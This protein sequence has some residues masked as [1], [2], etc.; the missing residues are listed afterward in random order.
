M[1]YAEW[2][3]SCIFFKN[4]SEFPFPD[5]AEGAIF[6]ALR[7]FLRKAVFEDFCM[8]RMRSPI[9]VLNVNVELLSQPTL[10]RERLAKEKKDSFS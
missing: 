7:I 5:Q 6:Q 9:A 4:E 10:V 1:I 2:I 3:N 8:F